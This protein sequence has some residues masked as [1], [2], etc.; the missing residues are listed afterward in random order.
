MK[1]LLL[2]IDMQN[3]YMPGQ[4]WACPSMPSALRQILRL[5]DAPSAGKYYDVVFTRFIAPSR[6]KGRWIQYNES[7]RDINS[8]SYLSQ[9]VPQLQPFLMKYPFYDKSTYSACSI[10]QV[11]DMIKSHDRIAIT[12]VV[13]ECCVLSTVMGLIDTGAHIV[14][15]TDAIAGKSAELERLISDLMKDMSP[16]HTQVMT[17]E[18]YLSSSPPARQLLHKKFQNCIN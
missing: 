17:T 5:L 18:A 1:D 10:L 14:Y 2:I 12:G 4:P 13:A 9:I 7:N 16:V 6:P 15:L 3:A 8:K 11:S